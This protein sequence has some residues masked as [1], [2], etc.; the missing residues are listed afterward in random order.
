[1]QDQINQLTISVQEIT[2]QVISLT[3]ASIQETFD[4]TTYLYLKKAITSILTTKP[5]ST[6]SIA[7]PSGTAIMGS[8][9]YKD[10]GVL[11]TREIHVYGGSAWVQFK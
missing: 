6:Y 7:S 2:K 11:A 1:M 5:T 9:W 3:R 8:T 10:T 4:P